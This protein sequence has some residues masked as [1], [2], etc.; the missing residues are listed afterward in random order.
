MNITITINTDNAAF[1][2]GPGEVS[3][4]LYKLAGQF[5]CL[6]LKSDIRLHLIVP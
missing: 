1:E 3:Q 2:E 6:S 5:Q 4:I